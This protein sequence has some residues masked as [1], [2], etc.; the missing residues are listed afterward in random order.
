MFVVV[1]AGQGVS[2]HPDRGYEGEVLKYVDPCYDPFE[3]AIETLC[4]P[5]REWRGIDPRLGR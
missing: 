1:A 5:W 4:N 3:E 2:D